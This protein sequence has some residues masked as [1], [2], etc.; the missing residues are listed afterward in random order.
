MQKEKKK[1]KDYLNYG[2]NCNLGFSVAQQGDSTDS[3]EKYGMSGKG[4]K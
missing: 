4:E 1:E 2:V 3:E